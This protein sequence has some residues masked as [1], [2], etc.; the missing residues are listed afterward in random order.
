MNSVITFYAHSVSISPGG[1]VV[2]VIGVGVAMLVLW[3][4]SG[5]YR[6]SAIYSSFDASI[7]YKIGKPATRSQMQIKLR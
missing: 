6:I 1:G 7:P 3:S 4:T 5:I 2:K